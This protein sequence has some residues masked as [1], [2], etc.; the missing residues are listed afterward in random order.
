MPAYPAVD[1]ALDRLH[2][3][4]RSVGEVARDGPGCATERDG[5]ES[6]RLQVVA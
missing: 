3:A 5:A 4:G 6:D 1:E 2:R